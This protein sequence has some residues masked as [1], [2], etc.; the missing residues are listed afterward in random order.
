[1]QAADN[2]YQPGPGTPP[3]C[4][5]GRENEKAELEQALVRINKRPDE[6]GKLGQ[7]SPPLV[8]I[9]PR[10]VGKTTLI[11]WIERKA[12]EMDARCASLFESD[13]AGPVHYLANTIMGE[14]SL[15]KAARESSFLESLDLPKHLGEDGQATLPAAVFYLRP[16]IER[17]LENGPLLLFLDEA[18][19]VG[20]ELLTEFCLVARGF[21]SSGR[22][23]AVV[24]AGTPGLDGKLREVGDSF[25]ED[26]MYLPINLL[27]KDE[28]RE[29]LS[30]PAKETGLPM[31]ED[32]LEALVEWSDCYP[33]FIQLAGEQAWKVAKRHNG[34]KITLGDA[35]EGLGVA[36]KIQHRLLQGRY[37]ELVTKNLHALAKQVIAL[38]ESNAGKSVSF[39]GLVVGIRE[40]NEGMGHAEAIDAMQGLND[41]G[42][43]YKNEGLFEAGIPSLFNHVK[44][45]GAA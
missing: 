8:L 15:A 20:Q 5:A 44:E 7:V 18:Y 4:L 21:V 16:I 41:L 6:H 3:P 34:T 33:F 24:L 45:Q 9:G 40:A 13:L 36:E 32:A 42:F 10:G 25:I 2:P 37:H 22:P 11:G 1:M 17:Q 19:G 28:A 35:K 14:E 30:V 23:L 38:I 29:A 12:E 26:S 31:D 43:V 27:A 39:D